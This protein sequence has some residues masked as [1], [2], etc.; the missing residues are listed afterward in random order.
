MSRFKFFEESSSTPVNGDITNTKDGQESGGLSSRTIARYRCE[1][2]NTTKVEDHVSFHCTIK[3]QYLLELWSDDKAKVLLEQYLYK[4]NPDALKESL[5]ATEELEYN[6]ENV[7]FS[8]NEDN[9]IKR[10]D[11]FIEIQERW[12]SFKPKLIQSPFY[13][14]LLQY[15]AASAQGVLEG[16]DL[17]FETEE[18]LKRTYEKSLFY[19]VL[20][21]DFDHLKDREVKQILNFN[22]QIF[23]N[24]P[25]ELELTHGIIDENEQT[26]EVMTVGSRL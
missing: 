15:S 24:I 5:I 6:K 26:M 23:V 3:K 20:F 9:T 16:G 8:L 18:S 1:Q 21:N 25:I 7:L 14:T 13:K 2:F 4:I 22:S 12:Q 17:E 11:N 10:I 19:H